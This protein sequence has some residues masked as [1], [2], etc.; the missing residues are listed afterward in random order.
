MTSRQYPE[1]QSVMVF[2]AVI[3]NKF[4]GVKFFIR[5]SLRLAEQFNNDSFFV[6]LLCQCK[7]QFSI[8]IQ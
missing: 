4:M 7:S 8:K 6:I 1:K 5:L 3:N 2:F